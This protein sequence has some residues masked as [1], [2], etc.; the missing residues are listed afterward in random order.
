MK[1]FLSFA[2]SVLLC[3]G[4]L[5]T[6][7]CGSAFDGNYSEVTT[8]ELASFAENVSSAE[9]G[10]APD[11]SSG[12]TAN[13]SMTASGMSLK[14]N[15][16]AKMQDEEFL[17]SGEMTMKGV[18]PTDEQEKEV[19]SSIA[20]KG[21]TLYVKAEMGG[22]EQKIKMKLTFD[23]FLNNYTQGMLGSAGLA[24]IIGEYGELEGLKVYMDKSSASQTKVKI[25]IPA[26]TSVDEETTIDKFLYFFIFDAEYNLTALKFEMKLTY[27][28][29]TVEMNATIEGWNGTV[30][31][32][33]DLDS[34]VGFGA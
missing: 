19:K 2:I 25:E 12:V 33:S 14:M 4:M 26:N 6:A 18:D 9:N 29:E 21:D 30:S 1:K 27:G 28:E 10:N 13:L 16:N 20:Y 22:K 24:D 17:M 32:P 15:F 34:Y 5:F 3:V 11:Y 8:S 23:E 31:L 7:G